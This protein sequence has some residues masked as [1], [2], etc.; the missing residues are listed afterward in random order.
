MILLGSLGLFV[1][2]MRTIP[3]NQYSRS[4]SWRHPNQSTV[5][6]MPPA[7]F[8]G[9]DPEELTI[10][11][12]LRPEVTGGI[13]SIDILRKMAETGRPYPLITGSGKII[14]S[15]VITGIQERGSRL[16]EDGSPRAIAFTLNLKKVSDSPLG[17]EGAALNVAVSVVRNLT[18]I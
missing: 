16:N 10:E 2:I 13:L 5:G 7:Q 12:E 3:F 17:L 14:G 11:A 15:F 8:T 6:T 18:G 1:F 4:Q 9:K